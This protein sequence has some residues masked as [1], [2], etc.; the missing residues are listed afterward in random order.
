MTGRLTFNLSRKALGSREYQRLRREKMKLHRLCVFCRQKV[1]RHRL[2][3][4]ACLECSR[5]H[6]LKAK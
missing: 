2:G 3:R 5:I 1:E 6:Q 4:T